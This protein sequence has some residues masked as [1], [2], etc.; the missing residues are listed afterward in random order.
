[1]TEAEL[2]AT[3]AAGGVIPPGTHEFADTLVVGATTTD[4]RGSGPQQTVLRWV[5]PPDRA[6]IHVDKGVWGRDPVKDLT[7]RQGGTPR[8]GAGIAAHQRERPVSYVGTV[9][10][11]NRYDSLVIDGFGTGVQLGD[12]GWTATSE[13]RFHRLSFYNC[14]TAVL[15][16]DYNTL[17]NHF[18]DVNFSRGEFGLKCEQGGGET[19]VT[20]GSASEM[21][22]AGTDFY[23]KGVFL[24]AS[25]GGYSVRNYRQGEGGS[26]RFAGVSGT[27]TQVTLENC[28]VLGTTPLLVGNKCLVD[29]Y[30]DSLLVVRS[31]RLDGVVVASGLSGCVLVEQCWTTQAVP[32]VV[33]AM[34]PRAGR[35][36]R[37]EERGNVS[38]STGQMV[39]L[40]DYVTT[41]LG[42]QAGAI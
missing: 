11:S 23:T 28:T 6:A 22:T 35:K 40:G 34:N 5:G 16:T 41:E 12:R 27:N 26:A 17:N 42:T 14:T 13:N 32:K 31:C 30:Y 8:T 20:G 33:Q 7:L 25:G 18:E 39:R 38:Y 36:F 9:C 19:H 24:F 2:R 37:I 29:V 1:M 4:I 15:L 10:G 3:I 21:G